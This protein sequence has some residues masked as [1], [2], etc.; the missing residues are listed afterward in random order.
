MWVSLL[1]TDADLLF[2]LTT[3]PTVHSRF[4]S[5]EKKKNHRDHLS[6][7]QIFQRPSDDRVLIPGVF[8][9]CALFIPFAP[10]QCSG[11]LFKHIL[12]MF[13]VPTILRFFFSIERL[14][15]STISPTPESCSSS[16]SL[17]S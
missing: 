17:E 2:D 14:Y 6:D 4:L 15:N 16:L 9:S 5:S 3:Y 12:N 13:V 8:V 10:K 11:I 1:I 7:S